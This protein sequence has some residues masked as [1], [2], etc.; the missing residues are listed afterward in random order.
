MATRGVRQYNI[1]AQSTQTFGRVLLSSGHH[2]FVADGPVQNGCPGEAIGPVELFLAGLAACGVELI[3]VLAKKRRVALTG[4][5]VSLHAFLDHPRP[6]RPDVTLF[7][8]VRLEVLLQGVTA[9]QG[10]QLV[11][12]FKRR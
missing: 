2:H 7:N 1:Q 3:Q 4:V 6:V 12:G 11:D 5:R 10:A 8:A 9:T